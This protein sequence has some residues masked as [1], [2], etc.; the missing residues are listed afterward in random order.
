MTDSLYYCSRERLLMDSNRRFDHGILGLRADSELGTTTLRLDSSGRR[1][2]FKRL[3]TIAA[4]M[5]ASPDQSLPKQAAE[6]ADL[7]GAYRFLHHPK[8]TPDAIQ[9]EHRRLTR[10]ACSSQPIV[11]ALEDTTE[12][13]FTGHPATRGLGPIGNGGGLG[14][15]QHSVLAVEPTGE[16]IG[17]LHQTWKTRQ[18]APE[19]ETRSQ[20]LARPRE[21][22]FWPEAIR[23]VGA[24]PGVRLVHVTDRGGDLFET[25]L[26][27]GEQGVGFLIRAQHNRN[28]EEGTSKLWPF[29]A[30]QPVREHRDVPLPAK[31]GRAARVA[32]LAIR[33]ARVQLDPPRQDTRFREPLTVWAVYALEESAPAQEESIEW[34]LLTSE[35]VENPADAHQRVDWYG[36]RW[37]IEEYHKAEKTGCQLESSQLR[38]AQA[39]MRWAAIVGV[40]AVRLLQLRDMVRAAVERETADP[41]SPDPP[42]GELQKRVPG[43]YITV[44]AA[45]VQCSPNQLTPAQ[46]WLAIAKRGGFIGRKSDGHPGWLTIWR[47]WYE[48]MLIVQGVELHER[49]IGVPTYG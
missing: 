20:R 44:V 2:S 21:S 33:Y 19:R 1:P 30:A 42:P 43:I 17:L 49:L 13:D 41:T 10:Q 14:L 39:I 47:G 45:L 6:W 18:P 28:V 40:Q 16:V 24:L 12:L 26:A 3:V 25:M 48:V 35:A 22:D 4:A 37:V 27:C 38:D 15:L 36:C 5:A 9:S 32:R 23:A 11:L 46:F 29:M 8:I 7:K 34:M 31:G